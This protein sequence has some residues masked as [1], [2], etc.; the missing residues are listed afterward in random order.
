TEIR[1]YCSNSTCS[2]P[3]MSGN[4]TGA[5]GDANQFEPS[6]SCSCW[7]ASLKDPKNDASLSGATDRTGTTTALDGL[8]SVLDTRRTAGT[9]PRI[10]DAVVGPWSVFENFTTGAFF[11]GSSKLSRYAL[12]PIAAEAP[13]T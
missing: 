2:W 7:N 6:Q 12:F 8:A 3:V 11:G 10:R 13:G 5:L 1:R 9:A 4:V